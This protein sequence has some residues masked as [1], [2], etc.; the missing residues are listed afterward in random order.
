WVAVFNWI[1]YKN[2]SKFNLHLVISIVYLVV[3]LWLN[4]S[5]IGIESNLL[6]NS[7][8]IIIPSVLSIYFW[9]LTFSDSSSFYTIEH[10]A[11]DL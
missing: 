1:R 7:I 3:L 5:G 10:N 2:K 11:F 9:Y 4:L 6:V 8:L